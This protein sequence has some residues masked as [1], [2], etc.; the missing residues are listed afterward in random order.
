MK[1]ILLLLLLIPV[2]SFGQVNTFP[3]VNNFEN[4]IPLEQDPNDNGDWLL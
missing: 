1:N 4:N 3:W 2:L